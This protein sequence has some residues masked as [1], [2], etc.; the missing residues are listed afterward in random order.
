MA[1]KLIHEPLRIAISGKSGCGNTTVSGLLA[2]EL[3]VPLINYTFRQ[4]A[5]EKGIS[6]KEIV[7]RAE[8]DFSFDRIVDTKQVE[9]AME[10]SCVLGSRLAIWMLKAADFRVYLSAPAEVRARRILER[11][12]G[13]LEDIMSFTALRDSEDTRRYKELYQI[14][15]ED[16]SLADLVVPTEK[17]GP[18]AIVEQIAGELERRKLISR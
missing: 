17:Y 4:L 14:D 15:N 8:S 18:E 13:K 10:G 16:T 12:G 3:G 5:V 6:F 11:E 1:Y 7:R 9:L 2:K